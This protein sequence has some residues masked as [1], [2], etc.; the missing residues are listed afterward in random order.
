MC[1]NKVDYWMQSGLDYK[2]VK[3]QC[4]RTGPQGETVTCEDC[5]DKQPWYICKHGTDVSEYD[6]PT[7]ERE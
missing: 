6:C 4:G 1:D 7:C 3:L 5:E 2:V